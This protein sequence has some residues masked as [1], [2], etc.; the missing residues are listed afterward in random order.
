MIVGS[1]LL[2]IGFFDSNESYNDYL[3]FAS[4]VSDSKETKESEFMREKELLIETLNE[5]KNLKFIYFSSVLAGV[6]N[7]PYYTHKLEMEELIKQTANDYII[8]K[9]P[10]II[11]KTGNKNNIFNSFK[12]SINNNIE[13]TIFNDVTRSLIDIND[14]VKIINFCISKC[15]REVILLSTIEKIK[16]IDLVEKISKYL[17]K[18]PILILKN[19]IDNNDWGFENSNI[20][21]EAIINIGIEKQGYTDNL[22]KKYI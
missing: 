1:G 16:V 6:S 20:I 21:K 12:Y 3:I 9:I 22:I 8:F 11:G 10:Q 4:G 19:N 2:A 13:I 14:L 18:I 17:N 15:N 5:H 7:T